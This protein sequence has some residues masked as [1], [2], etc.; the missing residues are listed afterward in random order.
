MKKITNSLIEQIKD[1]HGNVLGIGIT[2]SKVLKSIDENN[3][4]VICNLLGE[5]DKKNNSSHK[6]KKVKKISLEH[7]EK[8]FKK[9]KINYLIVEDDIVKDVKNFIH[10]S[11]YITKE[12]IIYITNQSDKIIKKYN[13]Y[14]TIIEK[15]DCLDGTLL[16]IDVA[17]AKN[18]K[19]KEL[20]YSVIDF[21]SEFIDT[22]T[23]LIVN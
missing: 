11:I 14:Q 17:K 2:D 10:N 21:F 16:V 5:L 4:I 19:L 22:I 3:N 18:Y 1:M 13:R 20:F 7:L 6:E 8:S 9:K 12:K 23:N 15:I